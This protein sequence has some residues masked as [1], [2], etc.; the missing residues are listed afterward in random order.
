MRLDTTKSLNVATLRTASTFRIF[1]F[2]KKRKTFAF[3]LNG[4]EL[5]FEREVLTFKFPPK[6]L[7][8]YRK[9]LVEG[10]GYVHPL[11]FNTSTRINKI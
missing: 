5:S 2:K 11:R 3:L 9:E 7:F 8:D 10:R 6:E 1:F 4:I